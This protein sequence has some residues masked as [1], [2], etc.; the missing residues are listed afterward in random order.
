MWC[1]LPAGAHTAAG[2]ARSQLQLPQYVPAEPFLRGQYIK[3]N[4]NNGWLDEQYKS[5]QLAGSV[6]GVNHHVAQAFSHY[7]YVESGGELLVCDIQ[8]VGTTYTDPQVGK[9]QLQRLPDDSSPV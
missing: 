8:G 9:G 7:T 3:Y 5:G 2:N 4:N 6:A 1:R